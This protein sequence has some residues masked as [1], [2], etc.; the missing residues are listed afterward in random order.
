VV[1]EQGNGN[2]VSHHLQ[3][4]LEMEA[5]TPPFD[6]EQRADGNQRIGEAGRRKEGS[7]VFPQWR[8]YMTS[9]RQGGEQAAQ[10]DPVIIQI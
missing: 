6:G 10:A 7:V 3:I 4:D 8:G 9:E 5:G 1:I 2:D